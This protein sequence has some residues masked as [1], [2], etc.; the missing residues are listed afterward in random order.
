MAVAAAAAERRGMPAG[1]R[2]LAGLACAVALAACRAPDTPISDEALLASF[3]PPL[4]VGRTTRT[5]ALLRFGAP[6]ERF[7]GDRILCW[8]IACDRAGQRPVSLYVSPWY[9]SDFAKGWTLAEVDPRV[10]IEQESV[11]SLVLVFDGSGALVRARA[12]RQP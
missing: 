4:E 2:S 8:R 9:G 1:L 10:R 11:R 7:E 12:L 3:E 6:V 5:D